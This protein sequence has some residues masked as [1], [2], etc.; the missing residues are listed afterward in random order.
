MTTRYL[1]VKEIF[2]LMGMECEH[3]LCE[4]LHKKWRKGS[5]CHKPR[6]PRTIW[7]VIDNNTQQ[8]AEHL[9]RGA[10]YDTK[11]EAVQS[12]QEYQRLI[13]NQQG[14]MK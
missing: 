1:I 14:E 2:D 12:V 9:P 3:P 7:L 4:T 10:V 13:T 5:I 8:R 11:R 6:A